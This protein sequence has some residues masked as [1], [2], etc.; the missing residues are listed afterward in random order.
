MID[1]IEADVRVRP[2]AP[3][4]P[5]RPNSRLVILVVDD[6]PT[7]QDLIR[8]TLQA[9]DITVITASSMLE[10]I[11]LLDTADI[12]VCDY[13]LTNQRDAG[14]TV[15]V[16]WQR[17]KPNRPAIIVSGFLN[18]R[19]ERTLYNAGAAT[20]IDK[21]VMVEVIDRIVRRYC[22]HVRLQ[23]KVE[24][25]ELTNEQLID[26]SKE[27]VKAIDLQNSRLDRLVKRQLMITTV[28]MIIIAVV[29]SVINSAGVDLMTVLELFG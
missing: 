21:A 20:V 28:A 9:R 15:L 10:A 29:A 19:V 26:W 24:A 4:V 23:F 12:L 8:S 3:P 17:L 1:K 11:S 25:L 16:E 27:L 7:A 5:V 18:D 14:R 22:E 6:D 13:V 2:K